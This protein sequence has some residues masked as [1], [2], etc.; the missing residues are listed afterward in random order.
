MNNIAT[1]PGEPTVH[2]L[3]GP[4]GFSQPAVSKHPSALKRA[5]LGIT[6]EKAAKHSTEGTEPKPS[7]GSMTKLRSTRLSEQ[8]RD[9][10]ALRHC[11]TTGP[12]GLTGLK[13]L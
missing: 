2:V 10:A 13:S 9:A 3:T 5:G 4:S 6:A 11:R 7:I 12:N 1:A 8:D